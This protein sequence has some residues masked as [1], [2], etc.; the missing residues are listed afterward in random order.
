[1]ESVEAQGAITAVRLGGSTRQLDLNPP[2]TGF[3]GATFTFVLM[4]G[5]ARHYDWSSSNPALVSVNSIGEMTLVAKPTSL[6]PVTITLKD[7]RG[8]ATLS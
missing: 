1:N 7:K 3:V 6:T 2:Q 8:G 4:G 5:N